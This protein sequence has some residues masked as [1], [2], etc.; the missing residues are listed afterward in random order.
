MRILHSGT[1]GTLE[2]SDVLI[3]V[4]QNPKK[5]MEIDLESISESRFGGRIREVI[6]ETLAELK[7]TDAV[8]RVKDRSALDCTIRA[9]LIAA[10]YRAAGIKTY[11]WEA[12]S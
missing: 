9:R 4:E 5:G 1:A 6:T 12:L 3:T 10:A 7:V 11:N 2:S 8:V